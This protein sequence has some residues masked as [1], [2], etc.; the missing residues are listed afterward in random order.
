MSIRLQARLDDLAA[1]GITADKLTAA[2]LR[3][4]VYACDR[5]D[6]P[7]S[8]INAELCEQPVKVC[9]GLYLWRI[10]AGAQIWL[11]EYAAAWWAQGSAMFRWAQVYALKN[12]RDPNA[13]SSVCSRRAAR[14]AVL[15]CALSCVCHRGELISAINRCYGVDPNAPED[16]TPP[17]RP[18]NT[19][20][21]FAT[22]VAYLEVRSG[23]PAKNWLWGKSL[24]VMLYTW[25]RLCA[26]SDAFGG[27][28][29]ADMALERDDALS[30]LARVINSIIQRFENP[31]ESHEK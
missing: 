29:A 9:A 27:K 8:D 3:A 14:A 5:M 23:I 28:A 2:E 16:N 12:A 19:A 31:P 15:K 7:Y 6:N 30:N 17:S 13:F 20:N 25:A 26:I 21:D 1:R 11:E 4:L 22:K 24:K 10:T 18:A